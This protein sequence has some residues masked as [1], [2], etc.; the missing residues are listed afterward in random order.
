MADREGL[1]RAGGCSPLEAFLVSLLPV[2]PV[3]F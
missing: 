2:Q 3:C 1:H